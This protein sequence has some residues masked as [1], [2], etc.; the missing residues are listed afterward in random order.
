MD[1][2]LGDDG[3]EGMFSKAEKVSRRRRSDRAEEAEEE[4]EEELS[5]YRELNT[6]TTAR[7]ALV[8]MYFS[9]ANN[10]SISYRL[11]LSPQQRSWGDVAE[12]RRFERSL[13]I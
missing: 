3:E 11:H 2:I 12:G 1:L 9:Q 8:Q 13:F 10:T 6:Q 4:E 5:W 7:N